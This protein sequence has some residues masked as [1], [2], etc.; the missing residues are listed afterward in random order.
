[1][2]HAMITLV[3]AAV[4]PVAAL[5]HADERITSVWDSLG[6]LRGWILGTLVRDSRTPK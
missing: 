1:V 2:L 4:E 5:H 3:P 6:F